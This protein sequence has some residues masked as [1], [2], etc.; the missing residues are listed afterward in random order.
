MKCPEC[1]N[2]ILQSDKYCGRCGAFN[3]ASL[4]AS[5][6]NIETPAQK[7][8]DV[9]EEKTENVAEAVSETAQETAPTEAETENP[10]PKEEPPAEDASPKTEET[11][12]SPASEP[13][14]NTEQQDKYTYRQDEYSY[15][16][17]KEKKVCS[18]SVAVFCVVM[19]FI[20]S[21]LCGIFAGM[22]FTERAK[23]AQSQRQE[24]VYTSMNTEL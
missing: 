10:I 12:V 7:S 20:L 3:S 21:V 15:P 14:P 4:T 18:L 6:N 24:T 8:E 2:E 17:E 16:K 9:A 23:H 1:G 11:P 13:A 22:Y 5:M 19:V